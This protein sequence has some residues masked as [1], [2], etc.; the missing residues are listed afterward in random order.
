M[1]TSTLID[2]TMPQLG[3]SV[4]EG[5]IG[6]WLR[7]IGDRIDKYD[8]LV[9]V[10]SDK[11][12]SELPAPLAGTLVE[13]LVEPGTTVPVGT[14]L[15]RIEELDRR[16]TCSTNAGDHDPPPSSEHQPET[17]ERPPDPIHRK[18]EIADEMTL[19]RTRSSPVVRRT[20]EE[21]GIDISE[22]S[23][24]GAG[25]RVTRRDV[26]DH[27]DRIERSAASNARTANP[28]PQEVAPAHSAPASG[29]DPESLP[30]YPG[31]ELV[32]LTPMRR[33]IADNM[34]RSMQTAPQATVVMEVDM[35]AVVNWRAAH[36]EAFVQRERIDL[37]YLPIMLKAVTLA[38]RDHPRLNAAWDETGI[39]HRRDIN[40]GVAVA[41]EDGLVVPVIRN[42]DRLTISGLAHALA[43]L[44]R[45]ARAGTLTTDDLAGGTFT[46]NNPGTFGSLV[47][48]PIL[49]PPQAG[50]LSTEA[51]IKRPV[52]VDDMIAIR[53][54]MN[55]SLS[56]DHRALDG[57]AATRFL[58]HVRKWL[59][60]LTDDPSHW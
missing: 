9:E 26:L 22:I 12:N 56:I 5:T 32:P 29:R 21:F 51:I 60:S 31:D 25:G 2:I 50:I 37:T 15:C 3:E 16:D 18:G 55:L 13:I 17:R 6:A 38:L 36:K 34:V 54:M 24:S 43:N 14:A 47:S 42:A 39:I 35:T 44:V 41:L 45:N 59:E 57:L 52:V 46:V 23:G 30:V 19:L 28:A 8:P 48:T 58:Q 1:P 20:A 7:S 53:S 10:E 11:A 27:L 49:V 33:A 40:I 4:T